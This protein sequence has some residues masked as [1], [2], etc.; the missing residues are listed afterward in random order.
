MRID[1]KKILAEIERLNKDRS[2]VT[3]LTRYYHSTLDI[4]N[5]I[6]FYKALTDEDLIIKINN[7]PKFSRY[8]EKYVGIIDTNAY[9]YFIN[10]KSH[11]EL[12][13][14]VLSTYEN[15]GFISYER[16]DQM[17]LSIKEFLEIERDFLSGYDERLYKLFNLALE[18]RLID[19]RNMSRCSA[20]TYGSVTSN[21]H[22]V[23][24]PNSLNAEGLGMV[25]HELGHLDSYAVLDVRSK[26]QV[27]DTQITFYEAYSHFMEHCLIGYLKKNHILLKDTAINEN[28]YYA[29]MRGYF[30]QLNV[31]KELNSNEEDIDVLMLISDS[32][33]Y[34]Y[35]MLIGTLLY[36]RYEEDPNMVK[37]DIDNFLFNQGL[38]DNDRQLEM[39]GL[40]REELKTSKVLAK[41]LEKH[42]E[43]YKKYS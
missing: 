7:N 39:L 37:K 33:Q 17:R 29:W 43:F 32:Y 19:M 23:T 3:S 14:V 8:L 27:I 16:Q 31:C 4:Y 12:S 21:N 36:E 22:Y 1:E 18:K 10:Q 35:G 38:V 2:R 30:E 5:L 15:S 42:N 25:S 34:S 28:N 9:F 20:V 26:K 11:T 41:R 13:E 24:L 6:H 40:T